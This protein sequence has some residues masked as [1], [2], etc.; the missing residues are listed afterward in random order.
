M[1]LLAELR[2]LLAELDVLHSGDTVVL[3]VSG[4]PDSLVLLHVFVQAREML[5]VRP[6]AVHVNHQMRD[7]EADAD[8]DFVASI[9]AAWAVPCHV[10]R[11]N[12]PALAAARRLSLEEAARQARY[13]VLGQQAAVLGAGV[14]AVGH[15]ADDQAETVLMH[16][17]RGAGLAGLRGMLPLTTLGEYHLLEPVD[18]SLKLLRPL[19]NV[20]RAEI[21][22]YC[23]AHDLAPRFDRS[24]LDLTYFRNRLRHEII[25]LLEGVNPN[26]RAT[27]THTAAVLAADYEIVHQQV[28]RAWERVSCEASTARVCFDLA[29]W[30]A[31]PLALQRAT[32]RRAV[33][34]LRSHLRDVSY[35]HVED[36]VSVARSG[37]T[38]AQATLPGGLALRLDYNRLIVAA[39]D[40]RL[41]APDW[42]LLEPG[43]VI[44]LHGPG[45]YPLPASEW[46]F[47]LRAYDGLRSGPQWQQLL[48]T[49]W[50][51]PLSAD[52][53]D[54][55]L[56]LRTRRPGDRFLPSGLGATQKISTYMIN[57]K[58]PSRQRDYLPLLTSGGQ[59]AWV[60]GWR[61]DQR[62]MVT[63]STREIWLASFT[64]SA[65]L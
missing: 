46:C 63:S 21:E 49:P 29:G 25:P 9:A 26:I 51:A 3:G 17:L 5:G 7:A 4:G 38:G 60:C 14:I 42:P 22:A 41:P 37:S 43:T 6:V 56:A 30:R 19:L 8:A 31:L 13:T 58:I 64:R 57:E 12:V 20:P 59:V 40:D 10:A 11:V 53:L 34:H 18:A 44:D 55:P 27:L 1:D 16:L 47:T 52:A 24:N 23:A 62:F 15:T 61:A 33:W 28:D 36:A 32:I 65:L 39:V 45:E 50:S 48:A 2:R 54:G 35:R